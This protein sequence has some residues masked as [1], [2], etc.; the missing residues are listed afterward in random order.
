MMQ[1]RKSRDESATSLPTAWAIYWTR[2]CTR[3]TS[4]TATVRLRSSRASGT[5]IRASSRC[6]P[7]AAMPVTSCEP[8]S[9]T[10]RASPSPSSNGPT[11]RWVSPCYPKDGWSNEPSHGATV[12]DASPRIGKPPLLRQKPG[13]SSRPSVGPSDSSR[14]HENMRFNYESDLDLIRRS[15][16]RPAASA[17]AAF[18]GLTEDRTRSHA[19]R[20]RNFLHHRRQP[21]KTLRRAQSLVVIVTFIVR[22]SYSVHS[23]TNL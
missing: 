7:M 4:R 14:A 1:A 13:C 18:I 10:S 6:L 23:V 22:I 20:L 11:A 3:P 17:N 12:A 9:R 2:S 5:A 15:P 8:P 16:Y 21:Q 19:L